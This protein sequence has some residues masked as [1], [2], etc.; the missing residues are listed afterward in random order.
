MPSSEDKKYRFET[1]CP[2]LKRN[3]KKNLHHSHQRELLL[4]PASF[5]E[6]I[7][8]EQAASN[9]GMQLF[10][11]LREDFAICLVLTDLET[12]CGFRR[13][14]QKNFALSLVPIPFAFMNCLRMF[15]YCSICSRY[16]STHVMVTLTFK[17][18]LIDW[19]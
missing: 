7:F 11:S 16:H 19:K 9:T 1:G 6:L 3:A 4:K 18:W 13:N 5:S 15:S 2:P 10:S 12:N 8:I 14:R 17:F